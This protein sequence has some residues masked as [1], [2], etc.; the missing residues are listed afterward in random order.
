MDDL[1]RTLRRTAPRARATALIL[2]AL[3]LGAALTLW[4]AAAEAATFNHQ[5]PSARERVLRSPPGA[6]TSSSNW[7]YRVFWREGDDQS[8]PV[9][10]ACEPMHTPN[11]SQKMTP[12]EELNNF[13]VDN[14]PMVKP[15]SLVSL[16]VCE[17]DWNGDSDW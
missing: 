2:V 7:I 5:R 14:F 1:R 8:P 4:P 9:Q 3:A 17:E 13:I 16:R 12:G 11:W 10:P 6:S 15:T